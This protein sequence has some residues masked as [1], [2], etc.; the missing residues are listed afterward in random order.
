MTKSQAIGT[1][2]TFSGDKVRMNMR[3]CR[4]LALW[5]GFGA[6]ALSSCSKSEPSGE[7]SEDQL[8]HFAGITT[9]DHPDNA[10]NEASAMSTEMGNADEPAQ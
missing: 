4:K 5:V 8:N 10:G 9:H 7:I 1:A 6:L 2:S 3:R